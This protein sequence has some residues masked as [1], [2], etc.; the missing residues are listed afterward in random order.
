MNHTEPLEHAT[1]YHRVTPKFCAHCGMPVMR[2][3]IQVVGG[4]EKAFCCGG[5]RTAYEIIRAA[6]ETEERAGTVVHSD[7]GWK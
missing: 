6:E 1:P 2:P 3:Q 7:W 4:Q 5:C